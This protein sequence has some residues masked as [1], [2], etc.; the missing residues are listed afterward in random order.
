MERKW[1]KRR[2][3]EVTTTKGANPENMTDLLIVDK[4][5]EDSV[6]TDLKEECVGIL[7]LLYRAL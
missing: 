1:K 7:C 2:C 5:I 4:G 6:R 3:R